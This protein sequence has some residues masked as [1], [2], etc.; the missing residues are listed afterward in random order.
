MT[1]RG[2]K[3]TVQIVIW[4]DDDAALAN[5]INGVR[6]MA[7]AAFGPENESVTFTAPGVK[8]LRASLDGVRWRS[9][10]VSGRMRM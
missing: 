5:Y 1:K 6:L 3:R 9:G 2:K 4:T 8:K 10:N 7:D